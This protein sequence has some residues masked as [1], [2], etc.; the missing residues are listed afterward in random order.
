MYKTPSSRKRDKLDAKL[1]LIPILDA[2]FIFIFFLLMSSNFVRIFE[3]QSDVPII[4]NTLPVKNT[5]KILALTVD[6][7]KKGFAVYTGLPSKL[8]RVISKKDSKYDFESLHQFLVDVKLKNPKEKT[9]ILNPKID[10]T[11]DIIV[12]IMD[13]V[14]TL[15]KTDPSIIF[16]DK[17]GIKAKADTLFNDIIFNN[18]LSKNSQKLDE[19]WLSS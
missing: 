16:T 7:T 13:A 8:I 5:N 6:I 17:K 11:Y 9:V 19:G 1:N 3:I 12:D 4:S 10:I 14:R 18:L 2:I 15:R